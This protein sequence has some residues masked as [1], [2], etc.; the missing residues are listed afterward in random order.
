MSKSLFLAWQDKG[1]SREW[2]PIGRLDADLGQTSYRFRYTGGAERAQSEA[3][4]PLLVEFPELD[5]D[6]RAT[7]LFPLFRNRVINP[8]RSGREDYL[9]RLDL[10][11]EADPFE[12][13]ATNG[14]YRATDAYEVF[15]K[16]MKAPD[17]SFKC[18]FFLH[19]WRYVNSAAQERLQGLSQGDKL[20]LTLELTNPRTRF[21]IQ[22]QTTDYHMIG[23]APRYL[24]TDLV[25]AVTE[26]PRDYGAHVVRVNPPWP[27]RNSEFSSKCV[28][29]GI[30]ISP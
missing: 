7:R 4:F 29:S 1:N 8:G 30:G 16:L 22:I 21:A 27:L 20:Y 18:R 2:F 19:G 12:I 14:G 24:V 13:L 6:Y 10:P 26:K 9:R 3:G 25:M 11:L 28:A 17:G 15:P 5:G 23:W